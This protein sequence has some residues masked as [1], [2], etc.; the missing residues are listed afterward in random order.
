MIVARGHCCGLHGRN[1]FL[2]LTLAQL[3]DFHLQLGPALLED[4]DFGL[5]VAQVVDQAFVLAFA[6]LELCLELIDPEP[7]LLDL[8]HVSVELHGVDLL[9]LAMLLL[10]LL[11]LL[12]DQD[13]LGGVSPLE[14]EL[15][16]VG[17]DD[18]IAAGLLVL[19]E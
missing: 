12:G 17:E 14:L 11:L 9:P 18:V 5:G 2:D 15:V 13:R 16:R 10:V 6:L 7:V 8:D 19:L 4:S 3:G 1:Y